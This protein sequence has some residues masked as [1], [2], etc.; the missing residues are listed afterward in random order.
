VPK[1]YSCLA[2]PVSSG[3]R[4]PFGGILQKELKVKQILQY[5]IEQLQGLD[6]GEAQENVNGAL[7][8]L[9]CA[10]QDLSNPTKDALDL[11]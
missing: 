8:Y 9:G 10:V 7:A 4:K 6:W 3:L 1:K 2:F 5:I 11:P